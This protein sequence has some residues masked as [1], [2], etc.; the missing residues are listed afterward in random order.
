VTVEYQDVLGAI[1]FTEA[2]TVDA[3]GNFQRIRETSPAE[4]S[5]ATPAS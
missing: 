2:W 1:I 5:V 3:G 4:A